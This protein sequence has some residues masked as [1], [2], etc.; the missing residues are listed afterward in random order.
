MSSTHLRLEGPDLPSLLDQVSAEDGPGA[1]VG[2][3]QRIPRGG[4]R[5]VLPPGRYHLEVEVHEGAAGQGGVPA[6]A[7]LPSGP[8]ART[9]MD[10]VEQ[11]N[12]EEHAAHQRH[13]GTPRSSAGGAAPASWVAGSGFQQAPTLL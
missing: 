10:L 3:A 11:L 5:G 2:H 13:A 4:G 6:T 7:G 12:Q 1:R 8:T 9:V